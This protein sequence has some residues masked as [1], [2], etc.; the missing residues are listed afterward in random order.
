MKKCFKRDK[1]G[2]SPIHYRI[3]HAF[4]HNILE[5]E[6]AL[7][8]AVLGYHDLLDQYRLEMVNDILIKRDIMD[9]S[10]G[11]ITIKERNWRQ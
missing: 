7:L 9:A 4:L 10:K 8:K 6:M 11:R 1:K 2:W 3:K 5:D